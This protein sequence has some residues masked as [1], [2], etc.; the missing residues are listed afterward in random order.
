MALVEQPQ[1]GQ[2]LMRPLVD[3]LRISGTDVVMTTNSGCA[4]QFRQALAE[5]GL[6]IEV[7]HPLE[8]LARCLA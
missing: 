7:V 5:A 6:G 8:L 3:E 2:Q 4:L 1:L